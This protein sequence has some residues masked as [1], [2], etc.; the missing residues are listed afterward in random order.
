METTTIFHSATTKAVNDILQQMNDKDL[1]N[2]LGLIRMYLDDEIATEDD[3]ISH[4]KASKEYAG[5]E[6]AAMRREDWD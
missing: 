4:I 6:Y 3:I 2:I 1:S 5:G